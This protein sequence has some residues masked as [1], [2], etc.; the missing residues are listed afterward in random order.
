MKF[1]GQSVHNL[2]DTDSCMLFCN[3]ADIHSVLND[4]ASVKFSVL[5]SDLTSKR[6]VKVSGNAK[7]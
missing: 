3:D 7:R 2:T 4:H 6:V 1:D 5:R